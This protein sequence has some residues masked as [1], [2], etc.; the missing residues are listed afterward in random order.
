MV[1]TA[2]PKLVRSPLYIQLK[3]ILTE[4]VK[5]DEFKVGDKFLTERQISERFD[6]SRA[7]ANKAL[8]SLVQEGLLCFHKGTGTFVEDTSLET[9]FPGVFTSFTN[10][11][12]AA[13]RKPTTRVLRFERLPARLLPAHVRR[14]FP[15]DDGDEMIRVE[16]LRLADDVPMILERHFFL[17]RLY[18]LLSCADVSTSVYD[19]VTK[20]YGLSPSSVD[21]TI[22]TYSFRRGNAVLLGVPEGTPGFLMHFVPFDARQVPLY[23]AEVA[24]RG[25]AY[26]FHNRIGP[27]QRHHPA[28]EEPADFT[29]GGLG[30]TGR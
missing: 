1:Q 19:M 22:R 26:E 17:S 7:T 30:R 21:E 29:A 2:S 27:I 14:R 13:G 12:L 3:Q 20:K 5:S 8:S 16:R 28:D 9:R 24:Y 11:T 25:D 18:P 4:L 15:V 10:K 6:V 23:F